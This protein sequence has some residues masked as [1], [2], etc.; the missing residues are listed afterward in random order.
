MMCQTIGFPP[1]GSIG[2][3]R[4]SLASRIR[5]PCP[6]QRMT[7]FMTLSLVDLRVRIDV[8]SRGSGCPIDARRTCALEHGQATAPPPLDRD[9]GHDPQQE[10]YDNHYQPLRPGAARRKRWRIEDHARRNVARLGRLRALESLQPEH[11]HRL[12]PLAVAI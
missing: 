6:P 7:A 3:G 5:V 8:V 2:F 1:I 12:G 4:S 10:S 11:E 9:A